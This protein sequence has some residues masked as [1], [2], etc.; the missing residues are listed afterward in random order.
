LGRDPE[1][2]IEKAGES[3]RTTHGAATAVDGCRY[4]AALIVGAL[5]GAS[6]ETLLSTR[7]SPIADY[8]KRA[9]LASEIDQIAAGSFKTKK[10]KEIQ[11]T[12]YVVHTLEA[13]LWAFYSSNSF[14]EGC[15][16]AVNL[17]GDADTCGAVYGQIA[18]AF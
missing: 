10:A 11:S 6:K 3:S 14:E 16:L 13:A 1:L 18:G 2:A 12:S 8:W 5:G 9:P 15:R 7:Y 17:G 4:F